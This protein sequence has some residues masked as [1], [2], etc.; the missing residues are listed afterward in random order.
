M[1]RAMM[2]KLKQH[3]KRFAKKVKEVPWPIWPILFI[4]LLIFQNKMGEGFRNIPPVQWSLLLL[5]IMIGIIGI[6]RI[7]SK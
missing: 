1:R 3:G 6:F 2:E 4:S 5:T 7:Q